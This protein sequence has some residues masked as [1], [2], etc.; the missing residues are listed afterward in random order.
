MALSMEKVFWENERERK[1]NCI[2]HILHIDVLLNAFGFHD[3]CNES[4]NKKKIENESP[5]NHQQHR[6]WFSLH[7]KVNCVHSQRSCKL[8]IIMFYF[9]FDKLFYFSQKCIIMTTTPI[10]VTAAAA[11]FWLISSHLFP[12]SLP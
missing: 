6:E 5:R 11:E 7:S 8:S 1:K 3:K 4:N 9:F 10:T 2:L 12:L